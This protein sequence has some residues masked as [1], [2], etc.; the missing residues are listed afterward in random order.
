MCFSATASLSAAAVLGT[1][2]ILTILK[3]SSRS[4][5]FLALLPLLFCL[6]QISEGI[7]WLYTG[8]DHQLLLNSWK[9]FYLVFALVIWPIWIP[10]ALAAAEKVTWR[11]I[12]IGLIFIGGAFISLYQ[13][14]Y[15]FNYGATV[16]IKG[17]SVDYRFLELE[18]T[19]IRYYYV[20]AVILPWLLSSLNHAWKVG[21]A[22]AISL[23]ISQFFFNETNVS[24]WC[25]FAAIVSVMIYFIIR[26]NPDAS[27]EA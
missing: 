26:D 2:G 25:F 20:V 3:T 12:V 27:K 6:Q 5:L 14:Y 23:A 16:A 9:Y 13:L 10:L 15:L 22:Y 24:V 19:N 1:I 11:Q 7:I 17:H 4:Q 18:A 8:T 21:I